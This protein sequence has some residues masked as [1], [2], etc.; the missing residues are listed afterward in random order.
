MSFAR[1]CAVAMVSLCFGLAVPSVRAADAIVTITADNRYDLYVNGAYVG[2]QNNSEP[3][4]GW[5]TPEVW[6]VTL[7]PGNNL[8]AVF[9]Q[10][11]SS[12]SNT[13]IGVLA[14]IDVASTLLT[15]T[16]TAWKSS[17]TGPAGW[18]TLAFDDSGW[19]PAFDCGPYNA[20]PWV[21]FR[22]PIAEFA[23]TGARWIW[24]GTPPYAS[25]YGYYNPG[26]YQFAYLRSVVTLP[27]V[28]PTHVSTWG[29]LKARFR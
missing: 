22:A 18:N 13:A 19:A 10:D 14:R 7:E 27:Y 5:E 12:A 20:S 26:G 28:T 2:S 23:G 15:I 16:N 3:G 25:G 1:G 4:Y 17:Q 6:R 21:L 11:E 9:A 29:D 24:A 8:I